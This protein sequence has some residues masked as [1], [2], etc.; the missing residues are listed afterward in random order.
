[1]VTVVIPKE[2]LKSCDYRFFDEMRLSYWCSK[3]SR[4]CI[5]CDRLKEE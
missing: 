1:M 2:Q 5:S 3:D 4:T